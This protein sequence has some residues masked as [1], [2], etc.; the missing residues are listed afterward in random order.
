MDTTLLLSH[1]VLLISRLF[2]V[3]ATFLGGSI[4][5][6]ALLV[7]G[8]GWTQPE[9]LADL[10]G[11]GTITLLPTIGLALS[12]LGL[13][14]CSGIERQAPVSCWLGLVINLFVLLAL[15]MA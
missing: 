3:F 1:P 10:A 5:P 4:L 14:V 7:L 13:S 2:G 6:V 15:K 11:T 9:N 8:I 12:A